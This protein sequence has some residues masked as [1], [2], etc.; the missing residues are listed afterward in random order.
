MSLYPVFVD[1]K[2]HICLMVGLGAVGRRKV[3]GLIAAGPALIRLV[4]PAPPHTEEQRLASQARA[5]GV[6]L[7]RAQ[8]PFS[9]ED[10]DSCTLAFAATDDKA[11]NQQ[12]VQ[13][14]RERTILC[15]AADDPDLSDFLLPAIWR[16]ANIQVAVSTSG[17]SPALAAHI[18]DELAIFLD[19]RYSV[20][21]Q[22]LEHLRP[23]LLGLNL[24]AEQNKE[25]FRNLLDAGLPTALQVRD[26]ARAAAILRSILPKEIHAG[27]EPFLDN[28]AARPGRIIQ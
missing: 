6:E 19:G 21:G 7:L 22:L 4:D 27:I 13:L 1:L 14:C 17:A 12:I 18:R 20:L 3:A 25:L 16:Q 8:R 11:V 10:L 9:P 5:A 2:E 23:L 24:G 26:H 15:N 28:L